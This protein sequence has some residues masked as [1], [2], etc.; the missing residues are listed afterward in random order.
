MKNS[1]TNNGLAARMAA[2]TCFSDVVTLSREELDRGYTGAGS[3]LVAIDAAG[4]VAELE[5]D[6]QMAA[7][8]AAF[9]ERHS[10]AGVQI[11]LAQGSS[12]QLMEWQLLSLSG[13]R[14]AEGIL[15]AA[16]EESRSVDMPIQAPAAAAPAAAGR[17]HPARG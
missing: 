14:I 8:R 1:L 3:Y 5:H 16:N 2:T 11:F 4:T 7:A 12:C 13:R 15:K 9:F 10:Q 6:S 17:G